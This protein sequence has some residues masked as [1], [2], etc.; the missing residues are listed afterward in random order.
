MIIAEF[1]VIPLGTETPG[2][3][4]YIKKALEALEKSGIKYYPGAMST[5]IEAKTLEEL[6][7]AIQLA[8]EAVFQEGAKRV[9]MNI[10]IDD[11][12]DKERTAKEKLDSIL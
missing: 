9:V 2:V 8:H 4:K 7:K 11:R 12:R 1:S 5:V 3:S 10:K 6:F